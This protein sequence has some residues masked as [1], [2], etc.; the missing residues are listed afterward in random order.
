MGKY[1]D[2]KSNFVREKFMNADWDKD[3]KFI[4]ELIFLER[5]I[6]RGVN[7][8]RENLELTFLLIN[9]QSEYNEILRELDPQRFRKYIKQKNREDD[10]KRREEERQKREEEAEERME[11][12]NWIRA[13]KIFN[14]EKIK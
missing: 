3:R 12:D 4:D 5:T 7:S 8:L 10:I 1:T 11:R 14:R 9:H 13:K 6:T 2:I